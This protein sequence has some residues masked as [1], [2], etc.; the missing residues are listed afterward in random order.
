MFKQ[1]QCDFDGPIVNTKAGRL[2]GF[3]WGSTYNFLG[4]T[5][6]TAER[7]MP[8]VPVAPWT[9]VK[10]AIIYGDA[11]LTAETGKLTNHPDYE[12]LLGQNNC[13]Y[14]SEDC[15]NLNV[16]TPSIDPEAMKPVMVFI[17]GGGFHSGGANESICTNGTSL[18]EFGDVVVVSINHRLSLLGFFD[19]APF[20]DRYKNSA[21][22]GLEDM[23]L[24]LQW[25]QENIRAFGGNP[26]NVTLFGHS[27]GGCKQWAL[28]QTPAADGLFHKCIMLSGAAA[29]MVFPRREHNGYEIVHG[30]LKNLGLE[31]SDVEKLERIPYPE[32]LTAYLRQYQ[33][34]NRKY[35]E[36]GIYRYVGKTILANDYFKGD[37]F[38]YGMR[39]ESRNIPTIIGSSLAEQESLR[40]DVWPHKNR[41]TAEERRSVLLEK[42]GV[43]TD[44]LIRLWKQSFPDHNELDLINYETIFRSRVM[45]WCIEREKLGAS[46]YLFL[47]ALESPLH[48]GLPAHHGVEI[49]YSFHNAELMPGAGNP[50]TA[51]VVQ[52]Q[53][54]GAWV[55]FAR[56]GNPNHDKLPHWEPYTASNPETLIFDQTTRTSIN[57][58][59]ELVDLHNACVPWRQ[60]PI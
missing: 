55:S 38:V 24:A 11:S 46:S 13:L 22:R 57:F 15:L 51:D 40:H 30:T 26:D 39:P 28:M 31:D 53:L 60:F 8:P 1:F 2:R 23:V 32:F 59:R 42:F 47:F 27:G 36:D 58:D 45:E 29:N 43:H 9:G 37:P 19:L 14:K 3:K 10:D 41:L 33:E 20:G 48:G 50:G 16:W 18:S 5:Y 7:F 34:M 21:N 52:D 12:A 4:I 49:A 54:C 56:T 6:G 17:A 44:D 35:R 25:I